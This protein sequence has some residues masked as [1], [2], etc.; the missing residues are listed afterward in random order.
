MIVEDHKEYQM[1]IG[2]WEMYVIRLLTM[3]ILYGN[4]LKRK[5]Y[6]GLN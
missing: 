2:A 6:K 4:P 3:V 5:G 1:N